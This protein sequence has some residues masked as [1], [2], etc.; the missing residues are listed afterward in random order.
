MTITEFQKIFDSIVPSAIAWK[1]DN[2][3]LQV[4]RKEAKI[5]NI[6]LALDLTM[7]VAKEA[8]KKKANLIITHH[9]LFFHPLR[10]ISDQSRIGALVQY[11]IENKLNV[12][13]AHTN[14][15]SMR[16]GVSAVLA[17]VLGVKSISILS[18]L[19]DSLTKISVFVPVD[20]VDKVA[21]A[22][23][24]AGAGTFHRYDRCSFRTEGVGTFRA[25]NDAN[26]FIGKIGKTERVREIRFEVL[27]EPWKTVSVI[28]AMKQS[29]PYEEVAYDVYPL[30]NDNAE[31]GLGAIGELAKPMSQAAFLAMVRKKLRIPSLRY[32]AGRRTIKTVAVCGGSGSEFIPDAL[33]R[34]ADALITADLKYHTFQEYENKILLV[35]AGHYETESVVLPILQKKL[36]NI[37]NNHNYSGNIFTTKY[38]TNPVHYHTRSN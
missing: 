30:L 26:P 10:N 29:H 9:P 36:K 5:T 19:K 8:K 25:M 1:S 28:N 34:N 2:V 37:L 18:P 7:D 23:H 24:D 31:Y 21:E 15:D 32:T 27:C 16:W 11:V 33:R 38:S 35:D 3:G 4:G 13:A 12:F 14:L 17:G 20:Y 6:I 22:M